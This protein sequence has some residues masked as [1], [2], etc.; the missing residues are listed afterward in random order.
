MLCDRLLDRAFPGLGSLHPTRTSR[1]G[2]GLASIRF[3]RACRSPD[4]CRG[5]RRGQSMPL[6]RDLEFKAGLCERLVEGS[7]ARPLVLKR[8]FATGEESPCF[9]EGLLGA[10]AMPLQLVI[11]GFEGGLLGLERVPFGV[12]QPLRRVVVRAPVARAALICSGEAPE[13]GKEG[14]CVGGEPRERSLGDGEPG[15]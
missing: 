4:G 1:R 3:V 14:H 2:S 10:G 8:C 7:D 15:A 6:A 9:G 12:T 5:E 11:E 13:L